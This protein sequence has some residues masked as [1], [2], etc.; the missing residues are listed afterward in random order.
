MQSENM[1]REPSYQQPLPGLHA[2][3]D[4]RPGPLH[5]EIQNAQHGQAQV[6]AW[7]L[8]LMT[9]TYIRPCHLHL[10]GLLLPGATKIPA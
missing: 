7:E 8:I 3:G 10:L 4:L 9:G 6:T 2:R 1:I 5:R